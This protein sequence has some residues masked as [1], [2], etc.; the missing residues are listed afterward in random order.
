M[1]SR[2]ALRPASLAVLLALSPSAYANE[3]TLPTVKVDA[4]AP[5]TEQTAT[6]PVKGYVAKRSATATKTDTPIVE[7]PQSISV[8]T[9]DFIKAIGAKRI[10]E[11]LGYVPGINNLAWGNDSRYDWLTIRGFTTF[12]FNH[13]DGVKQDSNGG[14]AVFKQDPYLFER[15][16]SIRGPASVLFGN[17]SP[18]GIINAVSKRPQDNAANEVG[19][20][21]GDREYKTVYADMTGPL[22]DQLNYRLIAKAKDGL[23][24]AGTDRDRSLLIAPSLHWKISG[25]TDLTV[26]GNY[27]RNHA[28]VVSQRSVPVNASLQQ[29]NPNGPGKPQYL[30]I[31]SFDDF[32]QRQ[33]AIAYDLEHR[34]DEQTRLQQIVRYANVNVKSYQQLRGG[35]D[36]VTIDANNPDNPLNFRKYELNVWSEPDHTRQLAV[37][38]RLEKRMKLGAV[39]H[40]VLAGVDYRRVTTDSNMSSYS[41]GIIQDAYQPDWRPIDVEKQAPSSSRKST[42]QQLGLYLQDQIRF[43]QGWTATLG[44]RWDQVRIN[45]NDHLD[46]AAST[47]SR[48]SALTGRAGLVYQAAN[49]WAPYVSY[50]TSFEPQLERDPLT[51]KL[52]KPETAQ[53]YEMGI[54]YM[55]AGSNTQLSAALFDLRKQNMVKRDENNLPF[56]IGE[57]QVRGLELEA[58]FSPIKAANVVL[59][60]SLTPKAV[61][62]RD[63]NLTVI[64]KQ[65]DPVPRHQLSIWGDYRLSNRLKL[66]LGAR[67][68]GSNKG[69][70]E[71]APVKVPAYTLFDAS[72]NYDYQQWQFGLNVRNLTDVVQLI[73]CDA[74]SC[75][76][77]QPRSITAN[78]N[79]RW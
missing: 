8:V 29:T 10:A 51:K 76:E 60:Y 67:Y 24:V 63:T 16:E 46:A 3:A 2:F 62:T 36:F 58:K 35:T 18:G 40:T 5:L 61:V 66:G 49:G 72:L 71:S 55:P 26:W 54:R 56:Q 15:V 37:D 38:N 39:E 34:L 30:G 77:G 22:N 9:Q 48:Q 45:V 44:G 69:L 14:F 4:T 33:Y 20:E 19:V 53:Q 70:D 41:T 50:A 25:Q 6:G 13:I 31:P 65:N 74:G 12:N 1:P 68:I 52:F 32:N 79:Y 78:V 47:S 59:A 23:M 75:N 17:A 64:G 43:A 57:K 73:G 11:T 28:G 42:A 21:L 7:T 27:Q